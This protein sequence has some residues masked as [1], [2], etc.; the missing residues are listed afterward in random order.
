MEP[1]QHDIRG[2][3]G[4]PAQPERFRKSPWRR[5]SVSFGWA[6]DP[7][8]TCIPTESVVFSSHQKIPGLVC[9][10]EAGA[11]ICLGPLP[12]PLP[13]SLSRPAGSLMPLTL[14]LAEEN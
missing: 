4:H 6:E 14:G 13:P 11:H 7:E 2:I 1:W 12:S 8:N 5:G 9:V 10:Q 3:K